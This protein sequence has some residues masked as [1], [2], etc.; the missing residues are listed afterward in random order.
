MSMY[1]SRVYPQIEYCVQF[2]YSHLQQDIIELG[3][4]HRRG[5]KD[6]QRCGFFPTKKQKLYQLL[7]QTPQSGKE[8]TEEE[9]DSSPQKHDTPQGQRHSIWQAASKRQCGLAVQEGHCSINHRRSN[10]ANQGLQGEI[11]SH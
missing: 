7:F 1:K 10:L 8:K 9:N 3:R 11:M 6:A 4:V 5:N 2:H